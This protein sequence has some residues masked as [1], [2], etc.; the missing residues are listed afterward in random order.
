MRKSFKAMTV[1]ALSAAALFGGAGS[2]FAGGYNYAYTPTA[3]A[4]D[5]SHECVAR[6]Q[7]TGSDYDYA[8]ADFTN[9]GYG[10]CYFYLERAYITN[11]V[12][13][14]WEGVGSYQSTPY[15]I[16]GGGVHYT[17]DYYDGPDV[18]MRVVMYVS[19][20]NTEYPSAGI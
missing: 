18:R 20:N 6:I 9:T 4:P 12:Q 1:A 3:W 16:T 13:G 14:A 8:T 19:W 7:L 17:G 5:G 15:T 11:G 2:A 10:S